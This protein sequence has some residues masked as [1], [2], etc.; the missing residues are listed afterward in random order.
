MLREEDFESELQLSALRIPRELC[1]AVGRLF[2]GFLLDKPRV[3]PIAED[4][5]SK[6]TRLVILSERVQSP[7]LSDIP[8]SKLEELKKLCEIQVVPYSLKLGYT[9][10]GADQ[11]LKQILPAGVEVPSS[12]ETIGH[13]AH[14]NIVGDLLPYKDVIAKVIYDK[15]QP[16][17]RT[18]VNKVGAITNEFRVPKFEVL[19]GEDD[20]VTD[21]KQYGA[22]FKLDYS[23]VYWNSRLE[24]EHIRLVSQFRAGETICDMFAGVGPFAIPA[25]QKGCIVY[26]NDLNPDSV[27]YLRINAEIN[28]VED[29][30]SAYNMDARAFM[31]HLMSAPASEI[32][33]ES[34][35]VILE[36]C[37]SQVNGR[38]SSEEGS[39]SKDVK[40]KCPS[41]ANYQDSSEH[42]CTT[43]PAAA[44]TKRCSENCDEEGTNVNG[45]NPTPHSQKLGRRNKKLRG[46]KPS[47][48]RTWEHIDHVIMNLP[49]SALQFL[50]VFKGLLQR[51]YWRGDL[52][53]IHC[54]CFMC[55]TETKESLIDEAETT[56]NAKIQDPIFHRVRDVAPNKAMFCLSFWL[57]ENCFKEDAR[58]IAGPIEQSH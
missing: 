23:L 43:A 57:P 3:K 29:C 54:Y 36:T 24:H 18:V 52:P 11:I 33:A 10:W 5:S 30:V 48:I 55:S 22:T 15:N 4:P 42:S 9:Y 8:E 45:L 49:A 40:D 28:K 14:L 39:L 25:A 17:I 31:F 44:N 27:H 20:M 7:D 47:S 1:T 16:K 50:D 41:N 34:L 21:V 38:V 53:W 26:A 51:K 46:F 37:N 35:P 32:K 58:D 13:I 19:E 56:L 6:A 2:N 12:F